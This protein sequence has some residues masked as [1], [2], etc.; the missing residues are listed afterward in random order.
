MTVISNSIWDVEHN[1][2]KHKNRHPH[3]HNYN[4]FHFLAK[5]PEP[6]PQQ[7]ILEN[8][9]DVFSPLVQRYISVIIFV[10]SVIVIHQMAT[11]LCNRTS[12]VKS[13]AAV[14]R[15]TFELGLTLTLGWSSEN[16]MTISLT[17]QD[18]VTG[19]GGRR[20]HAPPP[21]KKNGRGIFW[22]QLSC[23]IRAFFGQISRKI[24]EFC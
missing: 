10:S 20:A 18:I 2:Q 17:D 16:F 14:S 7:L 21:Q 4:R 19:D 23:K 24:R 8:I 22:G 15:D 9:R 11:T 1:G 13:P 5:P 12:D 3:H 6:Y